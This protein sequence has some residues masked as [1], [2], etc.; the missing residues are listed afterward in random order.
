VAEGEGFFVKCINTIKHIWAFGL[1]GIGLGDGMRLQ[2]SLLYCVGYV[3][4]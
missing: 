4:L 2:E 3:V 1:G